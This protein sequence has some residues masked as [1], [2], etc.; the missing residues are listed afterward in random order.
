MN[1]SDVMHFKE[2]E[3]KKMRLYSLSAIDNYLSTLDEKVEII[4]IPGCLI[5]N[6]IIFHS[7]CVEIIKE[8]ALNEWQSASERHIFQ[9][10]VPKKYKEWLSAIIADDE[11]DIELKEL[12]ADAL[13]M[14]DD[15]NSK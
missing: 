5:D 8:K 13:M 6:Y 15:F 9:K 2:K 3:N 12:S 11:I 1:V 14:I 7:F 10:R 4:E